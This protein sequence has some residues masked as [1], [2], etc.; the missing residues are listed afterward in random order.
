[1]KRYQVE[2]RFCKKVFDTNLKA[3]VYCSWLCNKQFTKIRYK[4]NNPNKN[5]GLNSGT[6][7]AISELR[8]CSD[9]LNKGWNVFRAV[10]AASS[11]DLLI[12]KE[13]VILKVEVTTGSLTS[14]GKLCHPAKDFSRFDV[15]AV[16]LPDRIVYNK[17]ME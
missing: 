10:S 2:C 1:M 17:S 9:L 15:L 3:Q 11:V 14:S 5:I 12:A 8:V 4:K 6:L 16:V 7:G 13:K